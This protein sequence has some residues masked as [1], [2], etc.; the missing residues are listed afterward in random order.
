MAAYA[1]AA[2]LAAYLGAPAPTDATRLLLRA[3]EV[4]DSVVRAPFTVDVQTTLPTDAGIATALANACCA[5]V[6]FW[7]EVGEGNDVDGL[8]ATPLMLTGT[9]G[10]QGRRAPV[11]GPRALR[12]L[13][14]AGLMGMG[15]Q[16]KFDTFWD[17]DR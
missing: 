4:L 12:Y 2:Q 17:S 10:F 3:S 9:T 5:Q 7:A 8:A 13:R 6:E 16:S 15:A 1:T 14:E 11:V